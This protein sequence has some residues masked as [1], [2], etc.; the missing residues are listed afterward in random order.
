MYSVTCKKSFEH[1]ESI[2]NR[3][4]QVKNSSTKCSSINYESGNH[5]PMV[6][7]GNKKDCNDNRQ[8]KFTEGELFCKINNIPFIETSSL[9][10]ENI[11]E[12]FQLAIDKCQRCN[13]LTKKVDEKLSEKHYCSYGNNSCTTF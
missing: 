3:I 2:R 4:R 8:V 13:Y 7:V 11:D 5:V 12:V 6:V 1:I 9:T 10:G